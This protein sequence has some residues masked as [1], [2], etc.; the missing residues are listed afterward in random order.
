M[1][2]E[3][4]VLDWLH[5]CYFAAVAGDSPTFEAWP[6]QREKHLHEYILALWGEFFS[7]LESVLAWL[8]P[9]IEG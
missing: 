7:F 8:S 1:S 4:E 3:D 9:S 5:D 2:Q 6:T